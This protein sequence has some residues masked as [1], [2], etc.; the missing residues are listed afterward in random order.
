MTTNQTERCQTKDSTI[1]P[2]IQTNLLDDWLRE[3][4]AK[5]DNKS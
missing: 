2:E 4:Q 1:Y 5:E 3:W